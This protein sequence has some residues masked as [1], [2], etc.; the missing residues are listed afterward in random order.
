MARA[1]KQK[2]TAAR[3]KLTHGGIRIAKRTLPLYAGSVHYW[4]LEPSAWRPALEAAKSLGLTAIDTYVPWSVH[5]TAPGDFDLGERDPRLD[6]AGFL[7][8]VHELEMMAIVR[9][10]P[11]IN[12]EL[13]WFG[14]PERIVWDTACQARSAR[15]K[16]VVLP[17]PP[18]AFPVPSYASE[19]F[20]AEVAQ[21]FGAVGARLS[22]LRWPDGPIVMVQ[23]DN[24]GAMY[25]RDGVFDQDYHP[26][27][28]AGY[29][30]F[31][32]KQYGSLAQLREAHGDPA[33]TFAKSDPPRK[34]TAKSALE[35]TRYL[36]WAQFQE[37]LL[38]DAFLRMKKALSSSGLKGLPTSHNLPLSEGATPLDPGRISRV[39]DL[40]GLDY[41]HSATAPQRS[42]IARRTS[43]LATRCQV[44][45]LPPFACELGA[46]FPPFF[47][48]LAPE[49]NAFTALSALAYGLKGF[50][51][52]MAVERDRW[53]GAPIDQHGKRR[54]SAD[55]WEKLVSALHRNHF[56]ELERQVAV[57]I[58]V[59][60]GFRRLK[61]VLH[62][63]GPLSAALFQVA[64]GGAEEGCFE[65]D[66]TLRGPVAIETQRFVRLLER[67]L[68]K[69][70]VPFAFVGGD[71]IG[72][73]AAAWTVVLSTGALEP[74][75]IGAVAKSRKAGRAV[76]LGPYFP[77]RDASMRPLSEKPAIPYERDV[78]IPSLLGLDEARIVAT[79]QHA[80][81]ELDLPTYAAA[82]DVIHTTVHHDSKGRP[83]LLFVINPGEH[84]LE[85]TVSSAGARQA[86]DA[87]DGTTIRASVG[88]LELRVPKRSVRMLELGL[89]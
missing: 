37:K 22:P 59:P 85:A 39:V 56:H 19:A 8:I 47:P 43:E 11:H 83:A 17:V 35:L 52:Y 58:V 65:D 89:F 68:E 74:E 3:L 9:P 69:R 27:A 24:E 50:N 23:V 13:T 38:A 64:G 48:P 87:F 63:F 36:D 54:A 51:L 18:L 60:R 6:V 2:G 77:E 20:H 10:G 61:R 70:R 41:Y 4:R 44:A 80:V 1:H 34:F 26:D 84:D 12:A 5:E 62:A 88:A 15:D 28:I 31:L 30:R 66:F 14:I 7:E 71:L 25:F 78:P 67:E 46:G 33:A 72:Q 21:W 29:R 75:I 55:F 40:V 82:P 76:S 57:H 32:Q 73:C 79:V 49:D 53:I 16:P 45:K 86:V 42:E 81:S